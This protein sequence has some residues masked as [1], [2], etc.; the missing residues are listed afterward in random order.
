MLQKINNL[1]EKN[2]IEEHKITTEIENI[3]DCIASEFQYEKVVSE[4]LRLTEQ[5]LDTNVMANG[6]SINKITKLLIDLHIHL[7]DFVWHVEQVNE[8]TIEMIK[9]NK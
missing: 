1:P 5:D 3:P 8:L 6:E 7:S 9:Q 4:L 2:F